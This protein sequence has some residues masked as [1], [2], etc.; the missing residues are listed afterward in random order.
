VGDRESNDIAGPL[1]VGMQAILYTGVI[2]RRN[3]A[4]TQANAICHNF[5][6][7]PR[8]IKE[9]EESQNLKRET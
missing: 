2:D 6:D 7:L 8:L 3:G 5:A 4:A 9:L 1:A